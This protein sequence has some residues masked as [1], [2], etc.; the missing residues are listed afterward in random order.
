MSDLASMAQQQTARAADAEKRLV[1]SVSCGV[2]MLQRKEH[3]K[4]LQ[5][6]FNAW[7]CGTAEAFVTGLQQLYSHL[8]PVSSVHE[9][10]QGGFWCSKYVTRG[11]LQTL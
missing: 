11:R 4:L 9:G 7:R 2:Q 3:A 8:H 1:R 5:S 10:P 6:L